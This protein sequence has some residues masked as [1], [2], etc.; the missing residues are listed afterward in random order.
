MARP[1]FGHYLQNTVGTGIPEETWAELT[2]PVGFVIGTVLIFVYGKRRPGVETANSVLGRVGTTLWVAAAVVIP[3]VVGKIW[4][5]IG[6]GDDFWYAMTLLIAGALTFIPGRV[7]ELRDK[8]PPRVK[9]HGYPKMLRLVMLV[10][11]YLIAAAAIIMILVWGFGG[12]EN[13]GVVR[14]VVWGLLATCAAEISTFAAA[15]QIAAA[16]LTLFRS[17]AAN[18][19]SGVEAASVGTSAPPPAPKSDGVSQ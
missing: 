18:T 3:L 14:A 15:R 11:E 8:T 17:V 1:S 16:D 12:A 10:I 13:H 4:P 9:G 6:T 7:G 19:T 5:H 2:D